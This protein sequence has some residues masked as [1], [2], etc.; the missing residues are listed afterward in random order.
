MIVNMF[1]SD[2]FYTCKLVIISGAEEGARGA[3][4][5]SCELKGCSLPSSIIF[6]KYDC[7]EKSLCCFKRLFE[8]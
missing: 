5:P 8:D 3:Q 6:W 7:V 2:R 4:P 1:F